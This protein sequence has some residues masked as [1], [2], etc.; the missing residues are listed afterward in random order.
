MSSGTIAITTSIPGTISFPQSDY[1]LT[2][3]STRFYLTAPGTAGTFTNSVGEYTWGITGSDL[4]NLTQLW[5]AFVNGEGTTNAAQ[6]KQNG[7]ALGTNGRPSI[8][9]KGSS[10][11][12]SDWVV[13]PEAQ[14][15][16]KWRITLQDTVTGEYY[17]SDVG[18]CNSSILQ[19]NNELLPAAQVTALNA[20]LAGPEITGA[21]SSLTPPSQDF[22]F[23]I[24]RSKAGNP[25][26][27]VTSSVV[28]VRFK[29][30]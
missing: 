3:T 16:L 28:G 23:P 11:N 8:T 21:N 5:D 30:N 9:I 25:L 22:T 20:F 24:I 13:P 27:Y 6:K 14:R 1:N 15:E 2:N 7:A 19:N 10:A 12:P 26:R 17:T 4:D 18:C 29:K